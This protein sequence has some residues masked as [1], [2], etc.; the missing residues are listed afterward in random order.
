MVQLANVFVM[1]MLY[2]KLSLTLHSCV[3]NRIQILFFTIGSCLTMCTICCQSVFRDVPKDYYAHQR[4]VHIVIEQ[5]LTS[6]W[7][8]VDIT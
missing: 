6:A 3:N 2:V 7:A 1:R 5:P 8:C 4:G